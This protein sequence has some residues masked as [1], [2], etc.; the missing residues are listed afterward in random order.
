MGFYWEFGERLKRC[1]KG[2]SV[3]VLWWRW[4]AGAGCA[5]VIYLPLSF[6]SNSQVLTWR[7]KSHTA[8]RVSC[9]CEGHYG[10]DHVLEVIGFGCVVSSCVKYWG[11]FEPRNFSISEVGELIF[12]PYWLRFNF[13]PH[14]FQT[15]YMHPFRPS[16]F[17]SS[18]AVIHL[19][20][21]STPRTPASPHPSNSTQQSTSSH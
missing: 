2:K 5:R 11:Q 3:N 16:H 7:M 17:A 4:R 8:M 13:S 21:L 12:I 15:P 20:H 18:H 10:F 6:F 9:H 19:N 1:C 14:S